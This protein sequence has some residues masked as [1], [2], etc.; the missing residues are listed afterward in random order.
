MVNPEKYAVVRIEHQKDR[1]RV[2]C[3]GE[4]QPAMPQI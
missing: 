1:F 2:Q 4:P 3:G